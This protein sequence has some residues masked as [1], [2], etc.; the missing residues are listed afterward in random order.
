[1]SKIKLGILLGVLAGI[2]DVIPMVIQKLSFNANLSAFTFWT[3]AGFMIASSNLK[4]KGVLK[5]IV[6]SL[7]LLAPLAS[8]IGWQDPKSLIPIII[9]NIILGSLLGYFIDRFGK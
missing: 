2:I 9:M 8:L 3:V 7:I 4:I 6:L 1:M 5:G